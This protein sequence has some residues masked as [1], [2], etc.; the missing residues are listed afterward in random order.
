MARA[1]GSAPWRTILD[2]KSSAPW[3]PY[4]ALNISMAFLVNLLNLLVTK[5]TSALTI[6]VKGPPEKDGWEDGRIG[7][8]KTVHLV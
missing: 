6:Q 2:F 8:V 7:K 4:L 5:Q 1:Q 3:L